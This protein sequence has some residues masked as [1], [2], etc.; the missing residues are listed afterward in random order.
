MA[1]SIRYHIDVDWVTSKRTFEWPAGLP[2][3][4]AAAHRERYPESAHGNGNN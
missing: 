3:L 2:K 4:A 1:R